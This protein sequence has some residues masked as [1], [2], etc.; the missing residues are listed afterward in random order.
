MLAMVAF[1][2]LPIELLGLNTSLR[3]INRSESL[4]EYS[5]PW[6]AR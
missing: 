6:D 5:L 2:L 4:M 1:T 3:Q